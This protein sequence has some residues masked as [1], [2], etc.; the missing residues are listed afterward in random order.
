MYYF[1]ILM[2]V[3]IIFLRYACGN[4][5]VYS[6]ELRLPK[7]SVVSIYDLLEQGYWESIYEKE[8]GIERR[9]PVVLS[10]DS[11]SHYSDNIFLRDTNRSRDII[12]YVEPRIKLNIQGLRYSIML[13]YRLR[14]VRYANLDPAPGLDLKDMDYTGHVMNL[15]M[16][17]VMSKKFNIGLNDRYLTSRR[18]RDMYL[19]TNRI[20]RAKFFRNWFRPFLEY[21]LSDR[22]AIRINFLYDSLHYQERVGYADEDSEGH[23][24]DIVLGHLINEKT[25][26]YSDCRYFTRDYDYS[27]GYKAYQQLIGFRRMLNPFFWIEGAAGLQ[28]RKFDREEKGIVEDFNRMV[29]LAKIVRE[30]PRSRIELIFT[31]FPPDM[32]EGGS[33]YNSDRYTFNLFYLFSE[34]IKMA[35]S[36]FYEFLSYYHEKGPGEDGT[37]KHRRDVRYGGDLLV[38]CSL[39][40]NLSFSFGY[41]RLQRDSNLMASD[42]RENRITLSVKGRLELWG[43]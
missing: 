17:R 29:A 31:H 13:D 39:N 35:L 8:F 36:T 10:L 16:N 14:V 6:E 27:T 28:M 21:Y 43:K 7:V 15:G 19:G 34:N 4:K 32:G 23:S 22:T 5:V 20:S 41:T 37:I 30:T 24:M 2:F 11:I 18:P 40:R 38:E 25:H 42:F 9:A 1:K 12:T 3:L 26:I 33:Y